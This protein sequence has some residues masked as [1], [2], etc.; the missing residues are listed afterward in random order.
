MTKQ[1]E[2]NSAVQLFREKIVEIPVAFVCDFFQ[3]L[4]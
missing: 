4:N 1:V 2:I 3:N